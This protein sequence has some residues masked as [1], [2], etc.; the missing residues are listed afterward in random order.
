M[1]AGI[2]AVIVIPVVVGYVFG[3][4]DDPEFQFVDQA[5]EY[6]DVLGI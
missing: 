6:D 2:F 1:F 3:L 4:N 5:H